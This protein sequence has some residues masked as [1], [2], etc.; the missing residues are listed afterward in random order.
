MPGKIRADDF[1]KAVEAELHQHV[2]QALAASA[3]RVVARSAFVAPP[4]ASS[5]SLRSPLRRRSVTR[6]GR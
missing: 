2:D 4:Q 5:S 3:Q 1:H 6:K